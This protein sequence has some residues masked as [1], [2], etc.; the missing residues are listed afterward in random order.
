M[1]VENPKIEKHEIQ[2]EVKKRLAKYEKLSFLEEYAMY[3]GVTQFLE[4]SLKSLLV[5]KFNYDLDDLEKKSLG[6]TKELLKKNKVR[7]D[8]IYLLESVIDYRNYIAHELL[9]NRAIISEY[10]PNNHYD[11]DYRLLHKAIYELEQL[12]FLLEWTNEHDAW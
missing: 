5:R 10:I 1:I 8:F 7:N 3:L 9:F 12:V 2:D 4:F 6:Q 11:K